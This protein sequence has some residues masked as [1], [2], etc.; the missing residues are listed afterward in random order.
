MH[1]DRTK[2]DVVNEHGLISSSRA[3]WALLGL[4]AA[5][6]AAAAFL[7]RDAPT[8]VPGLEVAT[9]EDVVDAV[10]HLAYP[11]VGAL[12]IA[13]NR[14][15]LFGWVFCLGALCFEANLF[16]GAY[17][18][19]GTFTHPG[20][21][22]AP[23]LLS[24]VSDLLLV[25]SFVLVVTMVPLLFPTG[26]PPTR[27][28]WIVGVAAAVTIVL[29]TT[30]MAIR[31]GPVDEDVPSSG[32]NPLGVRGAGGVADALEVVGLLLLAAAA[33][34]SLVSV[35]VRTR[36]ARGE[37]RRQMRIFLAGVALVF[38]V[39][40]IPDEP[41][42]LGGAPAQIALAFVGILAFPTAVALALL[43]SDRRRAVA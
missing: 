8:D 23:Q 24:L 34:G 41:L 1:E 5:L 18:T 31:P 35:V 39:F 3:G 6:V 43:R 25:P 20:S 11:L 16:A 42:G 27:R 22:P 40:F 38:L 19:Y 17:S 7:V 30:S 9:A 15:N 21:L 26:C 36:R 4:S 12:I 10:L 32:A 29:A 14:A 2:E 13:R 33:V 28:W 37:E